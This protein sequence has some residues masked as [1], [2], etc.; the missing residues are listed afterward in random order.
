[1]FHRNPL[2]KALSSRA[3]R[4]EKAAQLCLAGV[5][6]SALS[7]KQGSP[8]L[9]HRLPPGQ[10]RQICAQPP[11]RSR[12]I[13]DGRTG[14]LG[15]LLPAGKGDTAPRPPGVTSQ[16][17][18]TAVLPESRW[19]RHRREEGGWVGGD[20]GKDQPGETEALTLPWA[21]WAGPTR[22]CRPTASVRTQGP[23]PPCTSNTPAI[24]AK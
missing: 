4:R 23:Q 19:E 5:H 1:M 18:V 11:A 17:P 3:C 16:S 2:R 24:G 13:S 21:A 20:T 8:T 15:P 14:R 7:V 12:S 9:A 10:L 22:L 6:T